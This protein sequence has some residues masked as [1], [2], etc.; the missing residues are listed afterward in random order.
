MGFSMQL[1]LTLIFGS[2]TNNLFLKYITMGF[3]AAGIIR[4]QIYED[5]HE[6]VWNIL[7]GGQCGE[8]I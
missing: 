4:H 1:H 6:C 3:S 5:Q 7:E 8:L 2:S